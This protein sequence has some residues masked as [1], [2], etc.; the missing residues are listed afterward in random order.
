MYMKNLFGFARIYKT[1]FRFRNNSLKAILCLDV[2]TVSLVW[3]FVLIMFQNVVQSTKDVYG[4]NLSDV[5]S[6]DDLTIY[7]RWYKFPAVII[8]R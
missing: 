6:E 1:I 5:P 4:V 2:V 7:T 3:I 8:E